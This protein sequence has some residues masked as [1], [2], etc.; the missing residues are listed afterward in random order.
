LVDYNAAIKC[1]IKLIL[2]ADV[3]EIAVVQGFRR[4]ALWTDC[5]N[6]NTFA[7]SSVCIVITN[8]KNNQEYQATE[9]Q[10]QHDERG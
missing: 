6:T 10:E 8:S 4:F 3:E 1:S 7:F 2:A 5:I 9:G